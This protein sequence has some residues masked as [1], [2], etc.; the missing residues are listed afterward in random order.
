[1]DAAPLLCFYAVKGRKDPRAIPRKDH[2]KGLS[3]LQTILVPV[4]DGQSPGVSREK[5][6]M[7]FYL[8]AAASPELVT[9][10]QSLENPSSVAEG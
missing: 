6:E 7:R 4:T 2:E 10:R 9:T 3:G 5:E 8:S 1:M